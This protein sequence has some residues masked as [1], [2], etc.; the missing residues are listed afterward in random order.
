MTEFDPNIHVLPP[1]GR[2]TCRTRPGDTVVESVAG[3]SRWVIAA[4]LGQA[5]DPT[6]IVAIEDQCLQHRKNSQAHKLGPRTHTVRWADR[7]TGASY[8]DVV[9]HLATLITKK[10]FVER[11]QLVTDG[12]SLGRVVSDMLDDEK[13]E[14]TAIQITAGQQWKRRGK[15]VNAGKTFLLEN[16]AVLFQT[17]ELKF[18]NDLPLKD[19]IVEELSSFELKTTTA[20][21][22]IISGGGAS[23]HGDLGVA[24]AL[25]SFATTH[26]HRGFVGQAPIAGWY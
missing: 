22:T 12:S 21:N 8:V 15:Y 7:F 14:H 16:L 26:L 17:G 6:A 25:A 10:E 20:G 11:T 13:A 3:W 18:A 1:G 5:S 2:V 19:Q 23:H 9:N 4:D 24:L